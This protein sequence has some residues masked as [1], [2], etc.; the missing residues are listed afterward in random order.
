MTTAE[1]QRRYRRR[2]AL[3]VQ[4]FTGDLPYDTLA[5][6]ID[7]GLIDAISTADPVRVGRALAAL[8]ETWTRSRQSS[9]RCPVTADKP[10]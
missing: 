2:L 7:H 4:Y 6:M 3:G 9:E 5:A 10:P 8:A 1:R